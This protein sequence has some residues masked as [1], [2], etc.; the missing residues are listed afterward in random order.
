MQEQQSKKA[1][2]AEEEKEE[3]ESEPQEE[4]ARYAKGNSVFDAP[5]TNL[6][7]G[8]QLGITPSTAGKP[9]CAALFVPRSFSCSHD[10][11]H[12]ANAQSSFA[13]VQFVANIQCGM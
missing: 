13:E 11:L 3:S 6:A 10:M 1:S 2:K 12:K 9:P 8:L 7:A 5:V 4:E